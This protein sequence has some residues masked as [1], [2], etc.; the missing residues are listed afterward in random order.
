MYT[1]YALHRLHNIYMRRDT[2]IRL[3]TNIRDMLA[4][5]GRKGDS[6]NDILVRLLRRTK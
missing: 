3:R 1:M 6:Y 4:E 5:H 2:T